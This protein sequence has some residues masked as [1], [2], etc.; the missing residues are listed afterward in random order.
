M[1]SLRTPAL[2]LILAL[3][4][5]C[6]PAAPPPLPP[7]PPSPAPPPTASAAAPPA[8]APIVEFDP[9]TTGMSVDGIK[10]LCDEHLAKASALLGEIVLLH[11][12]ME[13][14]DDD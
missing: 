2:A 9:V 8:P 7:P 5:A 10:K 3:A 4:P 1:A 13:G 6:G 14:T 12:I 11:Q